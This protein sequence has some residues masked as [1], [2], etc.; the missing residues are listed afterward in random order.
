[1]RIVSLAILA[2]AVPLV[3]SAGPINMGSST[4]TVSFNNDGDGDGTLTLGNDTCLKGSGAANCTFSGGG[5]AG[6][7]TFTW[8]FSMPNLSTSPFSYSGVGAVTT[9]GTPTLGFTLS[10]NA[11]DTATGTF[12]LTGIADDG[13]PDGLGDGVDING[14]I[15]IDNITPGAGIA[16]FDSL[17]GL[18]SSTALSFTADVGDCTNGKKEA[19]CIETPDPTAQFISLNVTPGTPVDPTAPEPGTF[20]LLG[21]ASTAI[22][23]IRRRGLAR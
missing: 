16:A 14:N 10:D 3:L 5:T 9:S 17:F 23:L 1:M 19:Y 4:D 2:A 18:P 8:Q 13:V 21:F 15:T 12:S 7:V 22:A 20:A 6:G 11:G